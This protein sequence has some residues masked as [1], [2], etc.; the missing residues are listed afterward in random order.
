MNETGNLTAS[1]PVTDK[2]V[3]DVNLLNETEKKKLKRFIKN[4]EDEKLGTRQFWEWRDRKKPES[5]E[6]DAT[7]K[8]LLEALEAL[9]RARGPKKQLN[10]GRYG[11]TIR[12]LRKKGSSGFVI[13]RIE[14]EKE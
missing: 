14:K 8:A 6:T 5:E 13:T 3:R 11:Y 10:Y 1:A 4:A 2:P 9:D 12:R 7:A